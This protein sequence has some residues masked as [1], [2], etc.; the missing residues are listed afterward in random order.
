MITSIFRS[1]QGLVYFL[2]PP[3]SLLGRRKGG[4]FFSLLKKQNPESTLQ[5]SYPP[6]TEK[7]TDKTWELGFD[8]RDII[9]LS[10]SFSPQ[11]QQLYKK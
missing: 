8:K 10:L 1:W 6:F 9:L 2:F 4:N 7:L 3:E 5:K 11:K